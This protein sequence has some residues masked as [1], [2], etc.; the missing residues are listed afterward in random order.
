[1]I[2]SFFIVFVEAI[3]LIYDWVARGFKKDSRY[4]KYDYFGVLLSWEKDWTDTTEER[5]GY[6]DAVP[7]DLIFE[8]FNMIGQLIG[9]ALLSLGIEY[10]GPKQ[11]AAPV[12]DLQCNVCFKKRHVI[13][14]I[15]PEIKPIRVE[16]PVV[17]VDLPKVNID[18]DANC[19][20]IRTRCEAQARDQEKRANRTQRYL[21]REDSSTG[22]YF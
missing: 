2:R 22:F 5:S 18:F 4:M 20:A 10:W 16:I 21:N 7:H 11:V 9:Y 13:T 17:K 12:V 3:S 8:L 19:A 14:H 6:D 1:M 15:H